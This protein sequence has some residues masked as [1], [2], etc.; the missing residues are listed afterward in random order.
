ML[1]DKFQVGAVPFK[2]MSRLLLVF[3]EY[4][5]YLFRSIFSFLWKYYISVLIYILY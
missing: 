5:F 2:K 1:S 4:F 3:D